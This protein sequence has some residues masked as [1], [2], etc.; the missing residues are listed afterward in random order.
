MIALIAAKSRNNVIGIQG[1]LPWHLSADLLRFRRLTKGHPVI[2]GRKTYESII[3]AR[4]GPL[5]D[6]KNI[7]IS[8]KH[9]TISFGD[10]VTVAHSVDEAL[11]K[12]GALHKD[13]WVIG[14]GEMYR[15]TLSYADRLYI[16]EVETEC[17]GDAYFPDIDPNAWR[18]LSREEHR[19]DA[20]NDH[21]Y[22]FVVLERKEYL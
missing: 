18:E 13:A 6:R 11:A 10:N 19:A 8:R 4:G 20:A 16:T 12:A 2:M 15:Q 9:E 21:D 7:V 22:T 14:G 5:P 17:E 3:K 1:K